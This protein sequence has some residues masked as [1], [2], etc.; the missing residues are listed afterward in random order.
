MKRNQAQENGSKLETVLACHLFVI[1]V[2]SLNWPTKMQK[3]TFFLLI[4]SGLVLVTL[5]K[6]INFS[7]KSVAEVCNLLRYQNFVRVTAT[8]YNEDVAEKFNSFF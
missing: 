1:I 7:M 3:K 4:N 8:P 6:L 5:N 2:I